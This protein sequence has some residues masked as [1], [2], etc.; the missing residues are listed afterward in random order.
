MTCLFHFLI[1]IAAFLKETNFFNAIMQLF[2]TNNPWQNEV[3]QIKINQEKL[4][5]RFIFNSIAKDPEP[6]NG[7]KKYQKLLF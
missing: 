1:S 4:W 6:R 5:Q 2:N 7:V 3:K